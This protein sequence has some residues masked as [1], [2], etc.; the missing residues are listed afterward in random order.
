MKNKNSLPPHFN[1]KN[2]AKYDY[3]ANAMELLSAA[4]EWRQA[5]GIKPAG[6]DKK[7]VH[8]LIIDAQRDF[9]FPPPNGSLYVGGRSGTGAIDDN[10]RL[11]RFIYANLGRI[12]D[13]TTTLDTHYAFQIFFPAFWLDANGKH[14]APMTMI[15]SADIRSGKYQ[16]N[17]AVANFLCQGNYVWLR[18]Q[19]EF[20][21]EMLEK[22]GKYSLTIW[23]PHCLLGS[24]GHAL[25]GIIQEARLFHSFARG[26]QSNSEVK[27]T[28]PLTE[29]YSILRPEVLLRH[30]DKMPLT[31]KNTLFLEKLIE[32]DI[33]I[34]AGQAKSHCVA[35][36]IDDL[37]TEIR[38]KD[39]SLAKKVYLIEDCTSAV[40]VPNII[41][42]TD[43]ADKAFARFAAAGMHV[44]QSTEL[45]E[46]WPDVKL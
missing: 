31:Q 4:T 38:A 2:A 10:A 5:E 34:I 45:I 18:K 6:A 12:T 13:I 39:E 37:L 8:L 46:D 15:T 28:H 27:G 33:L 21:A 23:P 26:A 24:P 16:P 9:C 29:N 17:P 22:T 19:V 44:V 11:A 7:K 20:Y 25:A 3:D 40:V 35:W 41:D 32:A 42:F 30:D 36:T 14:P 43:E 1:P